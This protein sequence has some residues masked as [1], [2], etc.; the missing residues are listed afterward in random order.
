M[1][2]RRSRPRLRG[3]RVTA[4]VEVPALPRRDRNRDLS[5]LPRNRRAAVS[6]ARKPA[7]DASWSARIYRMRRTSG[8][9]FTCSSWWP[10]WSPIPAARARRHRGQAGSIP[11]HSPRAAPGSIG[12]SL[13]APPPPCPASSAAWRRRLGDL[14]GCAGSLQV[15]PV[16]GHRLTGGIAH[17]ADHRGEATSGFPVRQVVGCANKSF[18]P[19]ASKP[20]R[21]AD[22]RPPA[23][24]RSE[25]NAPG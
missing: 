6:A 8:G 16:D 17:H 10:T 25:P 4:L 12:A 2:P 24:R 23:C 1:P 14:L 13:T 9:S 15:R 3:P 11:S 18:A 19:A 5:P 21:P 22:R 20:S 7:P